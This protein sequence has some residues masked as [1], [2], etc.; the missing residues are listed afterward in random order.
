GMVTHGVSNVNRHCGARVKTIILKTPV[1][2]LQSPFALSL[3]KGEREIINRL[4]LSRPWF[5]KLTTNGL[6]SW[7]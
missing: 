5:D 4:K 6:T 1:A 3:S 2:R 7:H